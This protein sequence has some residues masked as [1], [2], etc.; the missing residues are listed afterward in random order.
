MSGVRKHVLSRLLR[1]GHLCSGT[2]TCNDHHATLFFRSQVSATSPACTL[3][4]P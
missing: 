2:T 4:S 3:F 1:L